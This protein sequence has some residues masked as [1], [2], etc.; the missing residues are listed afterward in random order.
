MTKLF[1]SVPF[2]NRRREKKEAEYNVIKCQF[3]MD[4]TSSVREFA[5]DR[6]LTSDQV[7]QFLRCRW[8]L[9]P[10]A[11]SG[12]LGLYVSG[13]NTST[14]RW[15]ENVPIGKSLDTS[16]RFLMIRNKNKLT[17]IGLPDKSLRT[18]L[19]DMTVPITNLIDMIAEKVQIPRNMWDE[20][21][22]CVN[23]DK[24]S[25][26]LEMALKFLQNAKS[27]SSLKKLMNSMTS[28]SGGGDLI[29]KIRVQNFL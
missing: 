3:L 6:S 14:D 25:K 5:I 8:S 1:T 28:S 15:L 24:E 18:L 11:P 13:S 19:M 21:A 9:V 7:I 27:L 29:S 22:L 2:T 10:E 4:G 17:K 23:F 26:Q 16:E 20:Y 12:Q